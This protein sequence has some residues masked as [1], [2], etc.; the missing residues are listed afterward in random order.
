MADRGVTARLDALEARVRALETGA[1]ARPPAPASDDAGSVEYRGRVHLA[2]SVTWS[3]QLSTSAVLDLPGPVTVDVLA[4][5]GHPLRLDVV[6][7]L[8]RAPA[9]ANELQ[10]ALDLNST[11]QV[12]HHLRALVSAR[13]VVAEHQ[14]Y[15]VAPTAVV[16]LLVIVLAAGDVAGV[17]P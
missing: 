5:L 8:L 4:A 9:S 12:Y 15:S 14:V 13:V 2:G 17:L 6:R 7:R 10:E 1:P 16:P 3:R 11:G